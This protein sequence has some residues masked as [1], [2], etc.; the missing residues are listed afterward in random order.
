[1]SRCEPTAAAAASCSGALACLAAPGYDGPTGV[2]T[3]NG[4]LGFVPGQHEAQPE[5]TPATGGGSQRTA[6]APAPPAPAVTAPPPAVR[7]TALALTAPALSALRSRHATPRSIVFAFV[8]NVPAK[9]RIT[10]VR[11]VRSHGHTRWVAAGRAAT[12]A[13]AAGRNVRRLSG[14]T[15]LRRGLYRLTLTPASGASRSI[16][17]AIR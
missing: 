15:R 14:G 6:T 1:M 2:G 13:A 12:I 4:V 8:I 3:P 5:A 16:T 17:F 11:R 7:L 9:V 10:L